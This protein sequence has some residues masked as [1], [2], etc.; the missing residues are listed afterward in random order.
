MDKARPRLVSHVSSLLIEC[1]KSQS[2]SR[3]KG[4]SEKAMARISNSPLFATFYI[5]SNSLDNG[6]RPYGNPIS[7]V[8][9][10]AQ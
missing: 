7:R 4:N 1:I 10:A 8:K 3:L 9:T 5:C 2:C 6:F